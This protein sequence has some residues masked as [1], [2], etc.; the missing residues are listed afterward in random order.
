MYKEMWVIQVD[1]NVWVLGLSAKSQVISV[2]HYESHSW[3]TVFW[4]LLNHIYT[5]LWNQLVHERNISFRVRQSGFKSW[6][7]NL[8]DTWYVTLSRAQ[9]LHLHK[10]INI[11][12]RI[13]LLELNE[14]VYKAPNMISFSSLKRTTWEMTVPGIRGLIRRSYSK[15]LVWV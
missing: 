5:V 2:A 6:L 10:E 11:N 15:L 1:K 14:I 8:L 7:C 9:A 12:F 4:C 13:W 3:A